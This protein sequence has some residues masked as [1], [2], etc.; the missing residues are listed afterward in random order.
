MTPNVQDLK[1]IQYPDPRLRKVAEEVAPDEFNDDLRALVARMFDLMRQDGGVGLA[2]PQVGILKRIFVINPTGK[3]GDDQAY[4]NPVL[5]DPEESEKGEEGCLSL[6]G[7]RADILRD[8]RITCA[9]RDP[10]GNAFTET[11]EGYK[12]RIWQHEFDHLNGAL[13]LD[14]M[15]PVA[16]MTHRKKI[17]DLEA[18]FAAGA[19]AKK[20][21]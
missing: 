21:R 2:A 12:A 10:H 9:A 17:K 4:V 3:E 1:I 11:A 16:K 18:K 15:G 13:I 5:S 6:P 19:T 14:R 20:P 7:I 8:F